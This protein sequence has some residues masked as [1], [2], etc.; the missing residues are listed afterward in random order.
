MS[1]NDE[2]HVIY[3]EEDPWNT[4]LVNA[5]IESF[6]EENDELVIL[7]GPYGDAE[8]ERNLAVAASLEKTAVATFDWVSWCSYF[9]QLLVCLNSSI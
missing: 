3:Y 7:V 9:C 5:G 8:G 6:M 1:Q 2:L 4:T